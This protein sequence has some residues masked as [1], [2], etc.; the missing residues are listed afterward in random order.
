MHEIVFQTGYPGT[1]LQIAQ[2]HVALKVDV[3]QIIRPIAN[4]AN[5]PGIDQRPLNSKSQAGKSEERSMY[6]KLNGLSQP[7]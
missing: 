6:S 1:I 7:S 3:K 4:L 2:R 5:H